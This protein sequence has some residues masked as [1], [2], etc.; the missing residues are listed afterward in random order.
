MSAHGIVFDES[1]CIYFMTSE[2]KVFDKYM[3]IW[4]KS[5]NFIKKL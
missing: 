1:E 3:D 5:Y 4:E 2:E